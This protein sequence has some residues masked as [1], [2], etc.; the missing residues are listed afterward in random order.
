MT[1]LLFIIL[2]ILVLDSIVSASEA[3]IFSIPL[4]KVRQLAEKSRNAK[5]LLSLKES[6]GRPI[7]TLIALSNLIT[8]LGSVMVGVVTTRELG[9]EWIGFVGAILTFIIMVF[10]EIIPK[11]LGERNAEPVALFM[12]RPIKAIAIIFNPIIWFIEKITGPMAKEGEVSISK[13]ELS[14]L[15]HRGVKEGSI[16]AYEEQMIQGVFKL[17]DVTAGDMMT[18]KPFVFFLD[19]KK[20]LEE[21]R[22][23]LLKENHSRI[24][25][26]EENKEKVL[27]I[28]HQRELLGAITEGKGETLVKDYAKKPLVVPESRLGEDLLKDF[29]STK[30]HLAVVVDDYGTVVGVVGLEDVL[31]EIVGEIVDE[32]DVRPELIKR[33]ARNIIVVHGQTHVP[34]INHFFNTNVGSKRTLN[35]FLLRRFGHLPNALESFKLDNLTFTVEEISPS[36]IERVRIVKE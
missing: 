17:A 34:H 32:K 8:I 18:P 36:S 26:Y 20:S 15:T 23:L 19:G 28:V 11:R 16:R 7:A 31:E 10:A 2:I 29:L 35:G 3:A 22:S 13:E 21:V 30:I 1:S 33:V 25:V 27:G 24:P 4:N 12:A 6:M 5:V 9:E 14:F